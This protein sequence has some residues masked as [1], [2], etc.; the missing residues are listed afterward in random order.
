MRA[1]TLD[2]LDTAPALRDLPAPV[3]GDG[4]LLVRVQASSANPVDNA[5]A[6]GMLAGMVEHE[7]PVTLGRDFA[8]VVEQAGP[9]AGRLAA[10]DA[11][12]SYVPHAAATVH[13]GAWADLVALPEP[14][15][16]ARPAG[17]GVAAAGATPLAGITAL[18]SVDA[19]ELGPGATVLIVGAT[20]GVGSF[21]VQ[22]AAQAGAHVIATARAEDHA[23]LRALGAGELVDRDGD[24]AAAVRASHPDGIDALI[25]LIS[26][27][28]DDFNA[29]AAALAPGGRA[30]S[31]LTG[32]EPGPGRAQI[33][34]R[35][36]PAL[37]DRLGEQ[38]AAGTL[39]VRIQQT[40]PLEQA[41]EALAA[42]AGAHTQGKL[43]IS[44]G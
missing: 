11:V 8:G 20:G 9:G 24:V 16:A 34:A 37:L 12:W 32:L 22:L 14:A 19:L 36:D 5:I 26:Y 42:L 38:I 41:G 29:Y 15:V 35:P 3:P 6:A 7:F 17:V 31:P 2:A 10:G 4:E 1:F 18:L 13:D 27:T 21:A 43:A 30:A 33:W 23:Y 40:Y 28:P 39:Q 44:L 25:D